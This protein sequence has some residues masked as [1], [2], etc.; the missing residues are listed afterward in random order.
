[1]LDDW[2]RIGQLLDELGQLRSFSPQ[3]KPNRPPDTGNRPSGRAILMGSVK[4]GGRSIRRCFL[5]NLTPSPDVGQG[6]TPEGKSSP[7]S[8][9]LDGESMKPTNKSTTRS[10]DERAIKC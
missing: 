10:H 2:G 1:M 8:Y 3:T 7:S 6:L 4:L 9:E 5:H